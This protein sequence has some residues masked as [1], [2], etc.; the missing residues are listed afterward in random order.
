MKYKEIHNILS[1]KQRK[2]LRQQ[3]YLN[4]SVDNEL[5]NEFKEYISANNIGQSELIRTLIKNY[6]AEVQDAD[7]S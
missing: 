3:F 6:L 5:F 4:C 2:T 1:N 7:R